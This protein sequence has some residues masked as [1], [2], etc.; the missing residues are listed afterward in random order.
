MGEPDFARK[1]ARNFPNQRLQ[2]KNLQ[3][4]TSTGFYNP[5]VSHKSLSLAYR[6]MS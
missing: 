6:M 5:K 2:N 3:S 4:L 1:T